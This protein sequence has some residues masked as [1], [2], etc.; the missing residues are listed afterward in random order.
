M[1]ARLADLTE[2]QKA[3]RLVYNEHR[4]QN[5][6]PLTDEQKLIKQA[7]ERQYRLDNLEKVRKQ[8]HNSRKKNKI[9]VAARK[10]RYFK[11]NWDRLYPKKKMY[12]AENQEHVAAKKKEWR[13]A[14]IERLKME[15]SARYQNSRDQRIEK[16][17]HYYHSNKD[18]IGLRDSTIL[19]ELTKN[20]NIPHSMIPQELIEAVRANKQLKR[21]I[22]SIQENRT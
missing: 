11:E 4:R 21:L 7:K 17:K 22:K 3:A 12:V 2:E 5:R 16:S 1:T 6:K 15:A 10:K 19:R 18:R 13:E 14:N 20:N 8:E 9:A